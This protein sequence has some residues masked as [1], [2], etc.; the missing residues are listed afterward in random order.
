VKLHKNLNGQNI[1]PIL[2]LSLL[3]GSFPNAAAN[4]SIYLVRHA[5]QLNNTK[6]TALSICGKFRATQ[7]A[8]LLSKVNITDIYSPHYH[9][10]I[11]TA[12][13]L[14]DHQ[15]VAIKNYNPKY[16]EQ[17]S[18]K[19]QQQQSNTFVVGDSNTTPRL[20]ELLSK[21]AV[22]PLSKLDYQSLYQ[23]QFVEQQVFLTIF[24]QPL[25]CKN[26]SIQK[27]KSS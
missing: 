16:L 22:E 9:H 4:Y 18:L 20:V 26:L 25:S 5:E 6:K 7:L 13:P 11:Q 24:Q 2:F 8:N 23:L 27:Q 10:A 14:A 17:L 12:Q 15:R 1:L 3:L 19:L 21:Q